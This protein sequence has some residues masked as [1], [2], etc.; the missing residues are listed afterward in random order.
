[1]RS[2]AS[3]S[4]RFR[5]S[6]VE[7]RAAQ[8]PREELGRTISS[9]DFDTFKEIMQDAHEEMGLSS[10]NNDGILKP[11][12][13]N[14]VLR[15]EI[16]G[17]EQEHLSVI[18]VP[19]IFKSTTEGVTTKADIQ[20][21][22]N[23]VKRYMDNPR[24][25]MLAV[26]PASI[27]LATQ[28]ILELAAEADIHGDR[29]LGVLTKP[30][31]VDRGAE[32]GVV[33]LVEGRARQMKL[34]WH[35]IRDP[36]QKDLQ[37]M[38]MDRGD[39]EAAFFRSSAPWSSI[40]KGKVGI[41]S[42]RLRIKEVL[43][44]LVKK[45]FPKVQTEIKSRLASCRRQLN[46]LGLE[47]NTSAEQTAYLIGLAS[48]FQRLVFLSMNASHGADDAFETS[49]GLCIAPAI[50]SRMK[51]FS[52]EMAEYGE[53]YSFNCDNGDI[54]P[55]AFVDDE[56][57]FDIRK[58]DDPEELVHIL[59]LQESLRYPLYG[60][61][62]DWLL[63]VLNGNQGFELGTFNASILATVMKKQSSKWED[64]SM[65]FVS[66]AIVLVHQFI[67]S[68]LVSICGDRNVRDALVGK[69]SDELTRRYQNAIASVGFLLKVEKS[70]T[71]MTMNHYFNE[72]L[73]RSRQEKVSAHIKKNAFHNGNHG[74]V[75]RLEQASQS[76]RLMSNEQHVVQ[77][78]HD[79]LKSYYKVCRKTFVGSVCRQSVIHYLLECDECPL[80]LFSPMFVS[81]LSAD[82]LEELAGE[83]PG[84]KRLR[85]QLTKEVASLAKAVRILAKI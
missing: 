19:G 28:E 69:L 85:A 13:S 34:G 27:D 29:T 40:E 74:M 71:P 12:F 39:L 55:P 46:G 82:A 31:L 2:A 4:S 1:M 64:I 59:H 47:R 53:S 75:V 70:N 32:S 22:R 14:D 63:Q 37:D 24:S 79:I 21:V 44:S 50:M 67:M 7:E 77:D 38:S 36:G 33:D 57:T 81:Q 23:M 42:L 43:S 62:N 9:L 48:K 26:V 76:V 20:L 45:E 84:L 25:V 6:R 68:A 10:N 52:D 61:T 30:D 54:A 83:A 8:H 60:E 56:D 49:P 16:S 15:L 65:G 72:N 51:V 5:A 58:E 66:D 73:Q 80:A 78:I 18:D 11:T 35:I 3:L 17:P 41:D